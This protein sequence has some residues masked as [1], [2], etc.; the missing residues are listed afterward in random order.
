M[1]LPVSWCVSFCFQIPPCD[2]LQER[3]PR[4]IIT[5]DHSFISV[6]CIAANPFFNHL[7]PS[8][9]P[10][11]TNSLRPTETSPLHDLEI[12][13]ITHPQLPSQS[14]ENLTRTPRPRSEPH[15]WP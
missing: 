8:P 7:Q 10:P 5:T 13:P 9:L 15:Q 3:I 14:Q 6:Q 12:P 1:R 11:R 4:F 2:I